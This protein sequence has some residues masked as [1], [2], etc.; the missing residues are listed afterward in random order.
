MRVIVTGSSGFIGTALVRALR[1]RGDQVTKV[2][3]RAAGPGEVAWNPTDGSI[4]AATLEGHDAAVHLAGAGIGDKRWNEA[5][6]REILES[7]E[8]GTALLAETLAALDAPPAVLASG[9]AIGIYGSDRGDIELTEQSEPGEGFLAEVAKAWEVAT[10]PALSAGIRV[11]HLR[12]GLVLGRS[13]GVLKRMAL[14]FR[15]GVGG[16]IGSGN[17]WNSWISLADEVGA[18]MYLL[19]HDV[20]GPVNLTAP[21]PV[22]NRDLARAI[23]R[24]LRRPALF[25]VPAAA[26]RLAFGSEMANE[27]IL[28][29]QRVVGSVLKH[30]G[31]E[32]THPDVDSALRAA[33]RDPST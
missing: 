11:V 31:Y 8:Q 2:V 4:D 17:Q 18:I 29:S 30:S 27:T 7:R 6:K 20:R 1:E 9:S 14:P 19:D 16:R 21:N 3:R 25:P 24:V 10:A 26:M 28:A 15:L 5:R 32:F 33:L 13:G 12:T 22:T 23:G